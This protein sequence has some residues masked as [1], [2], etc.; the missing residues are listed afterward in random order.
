MPSWNVH[1]AHA[2]RLLS[3]ARFDSFGI[4]DA[5]AFLFG[6]YVPDV[7]VGFMVPDVSFRI[8]YC[9]TH[10]ARVE[11]IPVPDADYFWDQYV[12]HRRPS[13]P[14]GESL[15]LGAWAHLV[16]DCFYNRE[17]RKVQSSYPSLDGDTLRSYKQADFDLFGRMLRA[18]SYV[19][20][21]DELLKAAHKFLP[22]RIATEDVEKSVRIASE[23][24][25]KSE[26][27]CPG[28][29]QYRMLDSEWLNNVFEAC[30]EH[31]AVWLQTWRQLE[32]EEA[33]FMAVDICARA[34]Q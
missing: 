18:Q 5:N 32:A 3:D 33:S 8:D 14:A 26:S 12:A 2:E 20:I 27:F 22:Y 11:A 15:V 17:F 25:R 34:G 1:T 21:T 29:E 13:S 30:H 31:V 10:A 4:A 7:Y 24:T 23:I 6:N 19:Q 16:A 28:D 9:V